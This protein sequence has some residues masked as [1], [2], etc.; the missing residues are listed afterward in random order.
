MTNWQPKET[1][2]FVCPDCDHEQSAMTPHCLLCGKRRLPHADPKKHLYEIC[3]RMCNGA[4]KEK[5]LLT[6]TD[7][8]FKEL[9]ERELFDIE[10]YE[11][12]QNDLWDSVVHMYSDQGC[13]FGAII[14]NI[15][16]VDDPT[17]C[18]RFGLMRC[19][20]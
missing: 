7:E 19:I 11:F 5:Y 9:K 16:R 14:W 18:E 10:M 8:Q 13:D 15:E 17:L 12:V 2:M 4:R 20:G 6:L 1:T 3:F